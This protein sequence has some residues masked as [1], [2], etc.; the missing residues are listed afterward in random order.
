MPFL[1]LAVED[2]HLFSNAAST[3]GLLGKGL[4]LLFGC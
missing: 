2:D 3:V 1:W 4:D